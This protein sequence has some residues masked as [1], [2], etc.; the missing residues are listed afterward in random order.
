MD[1]L[2]TDFFYPTSLGMALAFL[3]FIHLFLAVLG[4]RCCAGFSLV[5]ERRGCSPAAAQEL[6]TAVASLVAYGLSSCSSRALEHKLS[7]CGARV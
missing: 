6:L 2:G 7:H 3:K 1:I 5:A 4:L